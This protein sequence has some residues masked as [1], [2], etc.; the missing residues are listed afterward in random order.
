MLSGKDIT[1]FYSRGTLPNPIE[2]NGFMDYFFESSVCVVGWSQKDRVKEII[3]EDIEG[4]V[5]RKRI[6]KSIVFELQ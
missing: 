4:K 2:T 6:D 1:D 5:F 3:I